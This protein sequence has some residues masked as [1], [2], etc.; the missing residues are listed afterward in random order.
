MN[1]HRQIKAENLWYYGGAQSHFTFNPGNSYAINHLKNAIRACQNTGV[2]NM[3]ISMWGDDGGECGPFACLPAVFWAS[4]LAKGNTNEEDIKSKFKS[5]LGI[6]F[7]DF[8]LLDLT[9]LGEITLSGCYPTR[10]ILYNDPFIGLMDLTLPE[11]TRA[12]HEKLVQQLAPLCNHE[13]WGYLFQNLHDLCAVAA[14]KCDIGQKIRTA[15]DAADTKQLKKLS[16]ELRHIA[17]LVRKF[18]L[19][20]RRKWM[21]E[22]KGHGFEVS[23]ARIGG[24][25]TRL[26]CCADRLDDYITGRI[27]RIEELEEE[28]LDLRQPD[29]PDHGKCMYLDY[30]VR[31][32]RYYS[33]IMTANVVGKGF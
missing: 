2:E 23:D 3:M 33:D 24:V 32:N 30:W 4:E 21:L 28:L 27:D 25:M 9:S 20:F 19:S 7:D 15:Y 5:L 12:D 26:E 17:K 29:H 1:V 22:N 14:A 31:T 6:A 8:M 16:K 18:Y 10:Y 11:H 13:W